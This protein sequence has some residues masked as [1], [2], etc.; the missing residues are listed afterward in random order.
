MIGGHAIKSLGHAFERGCQFR[1]QHRL[2]SDMCASAQTV[3]SSFPIRTHGSVISG[4]GPDTLGQRR[5]SMNQLS[6]KTLAPEPLRK[7][8]AYWRAANWAIPSAT[9]LEQ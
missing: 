2:V 8:N 3:S 5:I 6:E 4:N 7:M 1:M 9:L